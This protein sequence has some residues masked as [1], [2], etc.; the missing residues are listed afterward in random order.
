MFRPLLPAALLAV[1]LAVPA[2][3]ATFYFIRHAE[4]TTNAGT[5]DPQDLV[6]PP[7]TDLGRRQAQDLALALSGIDL[8][9]IYVSS[10]Q[11]TSL[12]IAPTAA[13]F[14]LTP[15]VVP[16]IREWSFGSG[17][18]DLGAIRTLFGAWASGDTAARLPG[19]ADSE[20]L[21][22]LVARV[23]PAYLDIFARHADDDGVVAI[24]GHGGSIGWTMPYVAGNVTLP[25]A[26]SNN[27]ANTGIVKVELV[28]GTPYVSDWQGTPFDVPVAPVPL[29]AGMGLM[30]LAA[31][32]LAATRLGRRAD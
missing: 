22:E 6:D 24:V 7:L 25:F 30:L 13:A 15:T 31:G 11:R 28:G 9:D 12:T 29:P 21:D 26:L 16:E 1:A 20:S 17:P 2:D 4:S 14:G 10:Y 32:T 3:A 27:L 23:V 8:T 5:S 18:L 19:V